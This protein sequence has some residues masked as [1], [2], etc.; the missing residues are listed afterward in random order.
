[1]AS[2]PWRFNGASAEEDPFCSL[3][4]AGAVVSR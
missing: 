1:M 4:D 2:A 3:P